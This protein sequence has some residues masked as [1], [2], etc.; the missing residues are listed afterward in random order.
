[1]GYYLDADGVNS[2]IAYWRGAGRTVY[3]PRLFPG[4][5]AFSGQDCIRYGEIDRVEEVVF[6]RKSDYSF[7]ECLLPVTQVLFDFNGDNHRE[8]APIKKPVIFLRSCDL[9]GLD[10]LDDIYLRNGGGDFYY[11]RLREQALFVLMGCAK[12]WED[13][14]CVDM[15]SNLSRNYD[16]SIDPDENGNGFLLDCRNA[17]LDSVLAGLAA[18]N[19]RELAVCPRSVSETPTRVRLPEELEAG[20]DQSPLWDE[21]DSR[22]INCG[23]CNFV[24]PTCTCFSMQDLSYSENAANGERRRVWSSCMVDKFSDVAGGRS[25]RKK[26][27]QR[28]RFKAMHKVRD[29][30]KRFGHHMCVGCGRCD[31]ACPEYISFSHIINR[32]GAEVKH[33]R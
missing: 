4:G 30:K 17:P 32:L 23:R 19:G 16:L 22:C 3:A 31:A 10:R 27:G 21:Y 29:H 25:Y 28:M 20:L 26:N 13:C 6:N 12:A 2:L 15:G 7:K 8:I 5:A 14:F 18:R 1:M 33:E 9:H 24:C 11:R